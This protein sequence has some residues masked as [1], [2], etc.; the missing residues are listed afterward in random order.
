MF[1]LFQVFS[2]VTVDSD[3]CD[4]E[5]Q[6]VSVPHTPLHVFVESHLYLC[7]LICLS[8]ANLNVDRDSEILTTL[9]Q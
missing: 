4:F 2:P 7:E 8:F 3:R 6:A 9:V 1:Q 5:L